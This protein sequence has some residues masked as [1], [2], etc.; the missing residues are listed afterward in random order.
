MGN[1]VVHRTDEHI[2]LYA[3][4]LQQLQ[5]GFV[6]ILYP[7]VGLEQLENQQVSTARHACRCNLRVRDSE[8]SFASFNSDP[9]PISRVIVELARARQ[10]TGLFGAVHASEAVNRYPSHIAHVDP[11]PQRDYAVRRFERQRIDVY[12]KVTYLQ[13]FA[14]EYFVAQ[15]PVTDG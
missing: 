14:P 1:G 9:R 2:S 13:Q 10:L 6:E 7:S 4:C 3:E 5:N 8:S 11:R 15:R 12:L